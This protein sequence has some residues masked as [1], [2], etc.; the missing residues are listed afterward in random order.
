MADLIYVENYTLKRVYTWSAKPTTRTLTIADLQA[1]KGQKKWTQ[2]TANTPEEA[3]AADQAGLDMIICN[4]VNTGLVR[5]ADTPQFLTASIGLPDFATE[6]DILRE[7]FRC[8]ALGADAI[9][10]ARSMQIVSALAKEDI[11][12]MGHLGLVPRKSTWKGGLRAVGKTGMEAYELFQEF[13]RLEDAG[14]V[15]VEA[16][17]IPGR[18]MKEISQRTGLITV[19]LGSGNGGDVD[20]IFMEDACGDSEN[21]PRHARTFGNLMAL[22]KQLADERIKALIAFRKAIEEGDF[23]GEEETAGISDDEFSDFLDLMNK[24]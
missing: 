11:P 1:N 23:P 17:V 15:L 6:S 9:M 16:E 14:G 24:S 20:Y 21:P 7:A 19:S 5:S 2:I 18:I 13:K 4:S 10:T 8:L 3:I 22:R 12:V